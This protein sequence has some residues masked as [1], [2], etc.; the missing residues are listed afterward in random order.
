MATAFIARLNGTAIGYAGLSLTFVSHTGDTHL[1]IQ[2]L[3][4]AQSHRASGVGTALI[5]VIRNHANTLGVSRLP[6]GTTPDNATAIA[7]YRAML[8]LEEITG[9]GPRFRIKLGA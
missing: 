2:H 6:I 5:T 8:D 7:A 3:F 1:D 4:V 9:F